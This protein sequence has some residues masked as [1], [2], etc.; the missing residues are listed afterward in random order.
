MFQ[1]VGKTHNDIDGA[2]CYGFLQ[3]VASEW[4]SRGQICIYRCP[5]CGAEFRNVE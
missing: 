1:L 3:Y 2:W 4:G 5:Q